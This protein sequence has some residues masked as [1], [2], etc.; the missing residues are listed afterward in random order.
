MK[1]IFKKF[2]HFYVKVRKY[3]NSQNYKPY[4]IRNVVKALLGALCL[5]I[6]ALIPIATIVVVILMQLP[7]ISWFY[8]VM[9]TLIFMVIILLVPC[10]VTLFQA[11]LAN[12]QL[13]NHETE[14]IEQVKLRE[15]FIYELI[16][17]LYWLVG[18]LVV[19]IINYYLK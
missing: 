15:I 16:N 9:M 5:A 7:P 2:K 8:Y 4:G 17:P 18:V 14:G 11:I 12:Y 1:N 3:L 13:S 6:L 10:I 19:I